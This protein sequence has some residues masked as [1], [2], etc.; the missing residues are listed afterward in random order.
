MAITAKPTT[1]TVDTGNAYAP[2]H[3]WMCDEG[4]G[5]EIDDKGTG[6]ALKMTLQ[7]SDM[8][9]TDGT[10]GAKITCV[11]ST[12]RYALGDSGT[13]FSSSV[14]LIVIAA[15]TTNGN[16]DA[17]EYVMGFADTGAVGD[18]G[19]IITVNGAQ[20]WQT[21]NT[22]AATNNVQKTNSGTFYDSSWHMLAM[23]FRSG[24][25]VECCAVSLD[26]AAWE[27]DASDTINALSNLD[28]YGLGARPTGTPVLVF[29]GAILAAW[30]YE[31]PTYTS[32]DD[33][34][35]AA[36]YADPWQFLETSAL[37]NQQPQFYRRPNTL[38]RM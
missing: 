27:V 1:Y 37:T 30:V 38:L 22:D 33:A 26:G 11:A 12:S 2:T 3:L 10:L 36:L 20:T 25:A 9:G 13:L 21:D 15:S 16:A 18:R 7:N 19:G 34:W 31:D 32:L 14:C 24:T 23:K 6:T 8:W 4:S 17:N 28:R 35:I 5:T 29:D